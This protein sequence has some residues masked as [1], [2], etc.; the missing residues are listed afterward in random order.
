MSKTFYTEQ[1]EWITV[2]GK[3]CTIGITNYAQDSLGDVVF[4]E[5][6]EPDSEIKKG[7]C[8][9]VIESVKAAGEILSPAAGRIIECNTNIETTPE[10][11]NESPEDAAWLFKFEIE[12]DTDLGALMNAEQYRAYTS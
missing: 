6:P 2:E 11:V 9:V 4:V 8:V 1:H 3:V 5:L 10:L 7:D 12:S